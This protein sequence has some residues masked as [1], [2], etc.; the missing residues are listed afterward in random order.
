MLFNKN[1]SRI[2]LLAKNEEYLQI[3]L[4]CRTLRSESSPQTGGTT[5]KRKH[6][7]KGSVSSAVC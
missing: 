7:V 6:E 5:L 3:R 1:N 2:T 4:Y